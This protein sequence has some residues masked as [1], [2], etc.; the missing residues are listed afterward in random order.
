MKLYNWLKTLITGTK[1]EKTYSHSAA[2]T[3]PTKELESL[4][5]LETEE[6]LEAILI[7]D[8]YPIYDRDLE[9]FTASTWVIKKGRSYYT[10]DFSYYD[11]ASA[12]DLLSSLLKMSR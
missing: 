4:E 12:K 8:A 5:E 11:T 1:P 6:F 3:V 10:Y 9:E 7:G 2:W